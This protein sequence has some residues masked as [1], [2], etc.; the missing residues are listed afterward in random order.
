[1]TH[2]FYLYVAAL[3]LLLA[4]PAAAAK[5]TS[6]PLTR[7][8][9][10]DAFL[11]VGGRRTAEQDFL[12][13]YGTEFFDNAVQS[14][15]LDDVVAAIEVF[16]DDDQ[17]AEFARVRTR[18]IDSIHAVDWSRLGR[19]ENVFAERMPPMDSTDE[20]QPVFGPA[21]M[22]WLVQNEAAH[23]AGDYQALRGILAALSEEVNRLA[24]ARAL[25]LEDVRIGD[26]EACCINLLAMA[27][28]APGLH[29]CV[30]R[31]G[32]I[33]V[34]G[35]G[36]E[37]VKDVL[38]RLSGEGPALADSPRFQA[39]LEQLP[40]DNVGFLHFD[41]Q[42]MFGSLRTLFSRVAGLIGE[43]DDVYL[44]TGG[45]REVAKLNEQALAAY[46]SGDHRK[47]L[48]LTRKA[49]ET[50]PRD[51]IALYNL[52]CFSTLVGEKAEAL[53]WLE[54]A[55]E[56]GFYAPEKIR[57]DEDLASLRSDPRYQAALERAGKL[58]AQFSAEDVVI[59]SSTSGEAYKLY[60]EANRIGSEQGD[61]EQALRLAEQA[62]AAS[63]GDAR[64]LYAMSCYHAL[65]NHD[66]QALQ[67]LQRAVEAG[68][69]CPRHISKDP[70]L[71]G[72][73]ADERYVT[74]LELAR[75][76]ASQ[77]A[78]EDSKLR[79]AGIMSITQ[80]ILEAFSFLDSSTTVYYV[81]DYD[82][83]QIGRAAMVLNAREL[84]IYRVL[85]KPA[86]VG[87]F[88]RFLP[89][90]TLSFS[91]NGG[92]DL[93][94][95]YDFA[96]E[97]VRGVGPVGDELI[98]HWTTL[99]SELG[100]ELERDL[101]SWLGRR[102][103]SITLENDAGWIWLIEVKDPQTAAT[104][105]SSFIETL[106]TQMGALTATN[107]MLAMLTMTTGEL[108]SDELPGFHT[109]TL[110]FNPAEPMVWGVAEGCLVFANSQRAAELCLDT[111]RGKHPSI[112]ENARAMAEMIE[113]GPGCVA[114]ALMD[115]RSVGQDI[116][117]VL[118]MIQ[119]VTGMVAMA[120]PEQKPREFVTRLGSIIG[121][122]A[123]VVRKIDFY[124]ST[125]SATTFDGQAWQ[126]HT[127]T[128]YFSPEERAA[129]QAK[130]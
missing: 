8:V 60:L 41:A 79:A 114:V 102:F 23:A 123:G 109:L 49:H 25:T 19:Y 81:K 68:F 56:A 47:A 58:A 36:R 124:K 42:N 4:D 129:N 53:D 94:A 130:P 126:S 50:D 1:M 33:L 128:H 12:Y 39:A 14:G 72:L 54:K 51:S 87:E 63:P 48:E 118:G 64:V 31:H 75:E 78:S 111:A 55:V 45:N 3:V 125:A 6:Y 89:R 40:K 86:E 21:Q 100:F 65:L 69:Y 13:A 121:K 44:N 35:L 43:S 52:A 93:G 11:C 113:P 29:I 97:T 120:I 37:L 7:G 16:L 70:D 85:S 28:G 17:K 103:A 92:I 116:A 76:R 106:T 115:Q 61:Y 59:N 80:R 82:L 90:E 27:P 34:L 32:D 101:L 83:H 104:K 10:A 112:R 73:R 110:A 119:P 77:G 117:K 15:V 20:R 99:Q 30:A 24:G 96:I 62:L 122:V 127:V 91:I 98:E 38:E 9:P 107:P 2:T 108:D 46:R 26:A 105:L 18:L 88:M 67:T 57:T 5:D 71:K 22:A 95:A 84:P 74:A 66:D